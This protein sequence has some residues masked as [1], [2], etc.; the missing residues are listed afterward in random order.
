MK[1]LLLAF[2]GLGWGDEENAVELKDVGDTGFAPS[3]D[4]GA[5]GFE[6]GNFGEDGNDCIGGLMGAA[7][8]AIEGLCTLWG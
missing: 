6:L 2:G 8:G 3:R 5:S 1:G 4:G 7:M